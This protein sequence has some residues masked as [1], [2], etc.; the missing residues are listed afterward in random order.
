ML[1]RVWMRMQMEWVDVWG[2][3]LLC[4]FS[5]ALEQ[6]KYSL[7]R[8]VAL[9]SRVLDSLRSDHDSIK[10]Q[11][12][13]Q[14]EQH[15]SQL[16]RNHAMELNECKNTVGEPLWFWLPVHHWL[17][18]MLNLGK[19]KNSMQSSGGKSTQ[20]SYLSKSPDTLIE[21]DSSKIILE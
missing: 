19:G 21:N 4:V 17:G 18:D 20:L 5:Q 14:W 9:K 11:Q 12:R 7:Q 15:E 1:S 16:E 13:L 8:E 2:M 10:S 3:N 6:E